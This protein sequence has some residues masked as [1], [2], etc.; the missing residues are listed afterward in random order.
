MDPVTETI[1]YMKKKKALVLTDTQKNQIAIDLRTKMIDAAK[2]DEDLITLDQPA[3]TKLNLLSTV[4]RVMGLKLIQNQLLD[5]HIL[6]ALNLWIEPKGDYLTSLS[7]RT[8]IYDILKGLPCQI[9]HLRGSQIGKT[10]LA[11]RKHKKEIPEN[12]RLLKEIMEK[13]ARPIFSLSSDARGEVHAPKPELAHI[14]KT[15]LAQKSNQSFHA[16]DGTERGSE[17]SFDEQV[18]GKIRKKED[19][20]DRV[21]APVSDGHM[22]TVRPTTSADFEDKKSMN[23]IQSVT[24]QKLKSK[25]K[26]LKAMVR[27]DPHSAINV[28]LNGRDKS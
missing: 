16:T 14:L 28:V 4:Q 5:N 15:R 25:L 6:D 8:A 20:L 10:V 13:W 21:R 3:I 7:V 1:E 23:N 2:Q 26:D 18:A 9:D 24:T 12:K 27:K 11:L 19:G 17:F 22:F